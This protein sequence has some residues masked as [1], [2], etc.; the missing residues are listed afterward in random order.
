MQTNKELYE[1]HAVVG[2]YAANT[3][4][5]RSLNNAEKILIDRFDIKNKKVLVIGCG[6]GRV[7]ANLLLYG[8][9]VVGVDR[10]EGMLQAAREAFPQSDFPKLSFVKAE[11]VDLSSIEDGAFDVVIFPMNSIDYIETYA[12]REQGIHEAKKK[13]KIG[14][15]LVFSSHNKTGYLFSPKVKMS[16]RSL[17][18]F[19]GGYHYHQ[20]SVVGG[21]YI[22]KGDPCFVIADTERITGMKFQ[23]FIADTRNKLDRLF[24][25]RLWLAK[26]WFPYIVYVFK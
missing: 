22:F 26:W 17:K 18:A 3:T 1:S 9:Q 21:G 20:E 12:L 4:R 13:L 16:D 7:P 10:S 6:V 23:G 14:G 5:V 2:K 11:A 15:L 24:A 25:K 8:N 19:T